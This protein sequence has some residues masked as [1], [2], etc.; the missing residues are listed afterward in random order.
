[1]LPKM[2][3][4]H[5]SLHPCTFAMRLC[6]FFHQKEGSVSSVSEP[7]LTSG[8]AFTNRMSPSGVMPI[9]NLHLKSPCT[10]P[11]LLLEP[12]HYDMNKFKQLSG[13][14]GTQTSYSNKA[15]LDQTNPIGLPAD[16]G[17][18]SRQPPIQRNHPAH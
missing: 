6:R 12:C 9:P 15:I 3:I 5:S 13:L 7:G 14:L 18:M 17:G 1:M 11:L 2:E 16:H 8:L 10:L 4:D